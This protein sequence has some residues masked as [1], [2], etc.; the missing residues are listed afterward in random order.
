MTVTGCSISTFELV[1]QFLYTSKVTLPTATV[2]LVGLDESSYVSE[3][4][5]PSTPTATSGPQSATS[6]GTSTHKDRPKATPASRKT[7]IDRESHA[8]TIR[9]A[10]LRYADEISLVG[11][12]S[13]MI[14]DIR[15]V[16]SNRPSALKPEH[17]RDA[18]NLPSG[19]TL[20]ELFVQACTAEYLKGPL[21]KNMF[22]CTARNYGF[23]F[24]EELADIDSFAAEVFREYTKALRGKEVKDTKGHIISTVADPLKEGSKIT[25]LS[26]KR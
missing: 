12:F 22:M 8:I 1:I 13:A 25:I 23:R 14:S 6:V 19:H 3:E 4:S 16:I 9:V 24:Y 10:F 15:E 20:R 17:I 11:A 5:E 26:Y 18:F 7:D 21:A 2:C